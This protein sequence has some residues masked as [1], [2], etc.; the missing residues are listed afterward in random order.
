MCARLSNLFYLYKEHTQ[1][2]YGLCCE[3][4]NKPN[5]PNTNCLRILNRSTLLNDVYSPIAVR[6]ESD[7]L[8]K[9]LFGF[10]TS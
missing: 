10:T 2:L 3:T 1:F 4:P 6:K 8:D 7:K 9:S 5:E